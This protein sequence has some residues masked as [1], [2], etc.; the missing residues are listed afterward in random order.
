MAVV[1]EGCDVDTIRHGFT[2]ITC[3]KNTR[4]CVETLFA[5][6]GISDGRLSRTAFT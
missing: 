6:K 4:G 1:L 3:G 2:R 5:D